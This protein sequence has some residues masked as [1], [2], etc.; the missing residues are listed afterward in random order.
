[1]SGWLVQK[2]LGNIGPLGLRP[3]KDDADWQTVSGYDSKASAQKEI[4]Q[5][6]AQYRKKNYFLRL[7][8]D[9]E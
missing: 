7:H 3:P 8:E 5:L 1:M 2:A 9:T 6:R 4:S